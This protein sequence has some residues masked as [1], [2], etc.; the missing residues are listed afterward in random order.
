MFSGAAPAS[1]SSGSK[2]FQGGAATLIAG[3]GGQSLN[4]LFLYIKELG[5]LGARECTL[6]P[7]KSKSNLILHYNNAEGSNR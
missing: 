1:L 7:N 2:F 4:Y 5:K 6:D 3:A